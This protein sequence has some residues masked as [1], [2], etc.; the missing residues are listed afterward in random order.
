MLFSGTMKNAESSVE[1][2]PIIID[3]DQSKNASE[4][5]L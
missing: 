2:R 3:L 1:D 4:F 5:T